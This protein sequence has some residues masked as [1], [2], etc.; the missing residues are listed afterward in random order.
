M[1]T[2]L[3]LRNFKCFSDFRF[4]LTAL[5]A[6]TGYNSSG[7]STSIQGLLLISQALRAH[8]NLNTI[9]L[10]GDLLR[11]GSFVDLLKANSK[12]LVEIGIANQGGG[13]ARWTL[14]QSTKLDR[15]FLDVRNL[16]V[17][18][19]G[20]KL[21]L[22]RQPRV[23][24]AAGR[25]RELMEE[26]QD[27][28]YISA[29]RKIEDAAFSPPEDTKLIQG[30]V[31]TSGEYAPWWLARMADEISEPARRNS[32]EKGIT[33][34][35]QV[36]AWLDYL[37]PGAAVTAETLVPT[38]LTALSFA[39]GSSNVWLRPSNVGFGLT[40]SLP[41]L[42]ALLCAK[43]GQLIVIDSP[44]AHLHPRAQSLF[45]K[46]LARFANAGVR[47][48]VETHSDHV[49][50]GMRVAVKSGEIS[51]SDLSVYFFGN[52]DSDAS[53]T[54]VSLIKVD[55]NGMIE[56]W[57]KGFFDQSEQDLATLSGWN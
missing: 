15:R 12:E 28:I 14:G 1:I 42:V 17:R 2:E 13:E 31:G 20:G 7:K 43:P 21:S 51:A 47:I 5:T 45:G 37:F 26:I 41:I 32:N 55:K 57:P 16:M 9:A 4:Q 3:S 11:I 8:S 44:E 29:V 33:I 34:R 23:L 30:N 54:S 53:S 38:S 36:T 22:E 24:P 52:P 49:L 35:S 25:A 18:Q 10:N 48:I 39:V 19:H 6:L 40:Y 56:S 50:A 27:V 46:L